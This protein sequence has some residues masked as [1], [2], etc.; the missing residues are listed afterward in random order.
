MPVALPVPLTA[1]VSVLEAPAP[2][3]APHPVQ[4]AV[5]RGPNHD[6][7]PSISNYQRVASRSPDELD[8]LLTRQDT[9]RPPR[10]PSYT[11]SMFAAVNATD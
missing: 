11:A 4:A 6:L 1:L 8:D 5:P 9:R 2:P 3:L 7:A 10:L